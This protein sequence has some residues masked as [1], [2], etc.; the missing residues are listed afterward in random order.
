MRDDILI[1]VNDHIVLRDTA[2]LIP[3]ANNSRTHSE[4]Q[5]AQI[6]GS[7]KEFG[8]TNPVLLDGQSGIVAG[9]ARVM[10]A[11]LLK[12]MQVPCIELGY[13]T[14]AQRK[15]YVIA[16]NKLALNAGWDEQLLAIELKGL[17]EL[18]FDLGLTGF[19][20]LEFSALFAEKTDGLTDPDEAPEA[21]ENPVSMSGDLWLL[22]KHRILCGDST[23]ANDVER[24]LSGVEPHLMVTDPPYG[25][26]YD[27]AWRNKAGRSVNGRT[28]RLS[29]GK[30]ARPLG[31]RA[32][33]KVENDDRADWR[34]AWVLFPGTVAYVWHA[35]IKA[36]IVQA[37][38][39]AC[40][41][42]IRAQIVWAKN[43]FAI[44]RGHYHCKHEPCWYA[45]R[46]GATG[47]WAGD[48]RQT[49]VWD[50]H[51][52]LKSET[53]HGTQKPVEC[54][55]RPIENNSSPGQAV[56]EPFCGSGTTIIAAEQTGRICRAIE[57]ASAYVDVAVKRWQAFTGLEAK[58]D[59]DGRSFEEIA[60]ERPPQDRESESA[61][62]NDAAD[63]ERHLPS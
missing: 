29:S 39:E 26:N 2:S 56:Y 5:I 45:V 30:A 58:L 4:A 41:F 32:V 40:S 57:I 15:A 17:G 36:G 37:S 52:N 35:G 48:H 25:V 24:V 16:D 34:E 53:G 46:K 49:T 63:L 6:A 19:G 20:E 10:A 50:I 31:A 42:D 9:H 11:Q 28:V 18:G 59:G 38:L 44:G 47:Q 7:I 61:R 22:G 33:G 54:M 1:K 21:P 51:K 8:F 13:L 14:E 27:P 55:R 12:M 23:V 3:Y 60:L 43:N 62:R